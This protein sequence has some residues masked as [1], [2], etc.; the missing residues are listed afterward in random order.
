[1]LEAF[2]PSLYFADG[3]TVSFHGFPYPTR[4][5]LVHLSDGSLWVWSPIALTDELAKAVEAIGPVRHIV[6]PNKLH[7]LFL[8]EWAERWPDARLYAPPGLARKKPQLRF[9]AELLDRPDPAWAADLDQVI[10]HGSL[11]MEEV[12]FFHRL[13]NTAIICD[14]IQQPLPK[15][16]TGLKR[17]LAKLGGLTGDHGSTP[18]DW[19]FSFLRRGPARA[20]RQTVLDWKPEQLLVAHGPCAK[21]GATEII[22]DALRWM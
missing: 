14:L 13:S 22:N 16:A 3:P 6:S 10:F 19:R 7:N 15:D 1:M 2:G 17:L 20:A 5:A 8:G 21:T 18:R 12:V 11:A 4:M 9:H